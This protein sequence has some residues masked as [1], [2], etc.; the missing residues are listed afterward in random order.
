MGGAE[1]NITVAVVLSDLKEQKTLSM[2][3][4]VHIMSLVC[5]RMQKL[6]DDGRL[7]L[8]CMPENIYVCLEKDGS[9]KNIEL[10]GCDEAMKISD[11]HRYGYK[12]D[13]KMYGWASFEQMN[14]EKRLIDVQADIFSVGALFLW[15]VTNK[16][17]VIGK[18]FDSDISTSGFAWKNVVD[19]FSD[20]DEEIV[21]LSKKILT[22]CLYIAANS[23]YINIVLLKKDFHRLEKK[24]YALE[25]KHQYAALETM[26]DN[27]GIIKLDNGAIYEGNLANGIRHGKGK[28]IYANGDIYEGGWKSGKR[29]GFG[30]L[31]LINGEIYEGEFVKGLREGQGK[32]IYANGDV[33][34]GKW[35]HGKRHGYGELKSGSN[36]LYKGEWLHDRQNNADGI[37]HQSE[38]KWD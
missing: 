38:N 20:Y 4:M 2:A 27:L 28:Q 36:L 19:M 7:Y 11:V 30:V 21:Q 24:L 37:E 34:E 26:N 17:L 15:L 1:N 32:Q 25:S 22:N 5:D 12:Y 10:S 18:E 9:A 13:S 14:E 3:E 16:K 35:K 23:R 8:K 29:E 33:Y 6:H 31:K